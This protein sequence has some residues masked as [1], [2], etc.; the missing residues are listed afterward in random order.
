MPS[1]DKDQEKVVHG[2][3]T[4]PLDAAAKKVVD[5]SSAALDYL[6]RGAKL[7]KC[8]WGLDYDD[9]IRLLMPH[10]GKARTLAQLAALRARSEFERGDAKAGVADVV[11]MLNLARHVQTDPLPID[12]LV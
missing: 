4:V 5:Q 10:A 9:G 12:Q 11:A 6:H 8:D 2:W 1:L 3:E 7:D